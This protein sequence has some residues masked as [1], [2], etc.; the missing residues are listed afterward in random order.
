MKNYFLVS[1]T[2]VALIALW[3]TLFLLATAALALAFQAVWNWAIIDMFSIPVITYKQSFGVI[4]IVEL[5][6]GFFIRRK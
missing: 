1:L 5:I 6:S 2:V 4:L 3:L